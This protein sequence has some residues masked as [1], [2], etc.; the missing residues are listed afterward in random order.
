MPRRALDRDWDDLMA[1]CR[2]EADLKR[3]AEH[4]KLLRLVSRQIDIAAQTLGFAEE[5][6]RLREFRAEKEHG[7]VIRILTRRSDRAAAGDGDH[8]DSLD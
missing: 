5:E 3:A 4:P 8:R 2:R 6:I 1:L 7:R